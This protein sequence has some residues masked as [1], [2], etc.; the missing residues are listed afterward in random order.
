MV[1][2]IPLHEELAKIAPISV[3]SENIDGEINVSYLSEPTAEERSAVDQVVYQWPL[4]KSK[5]EADEEIDEAV[6]QVEEAGFDTG[7]GY[8]IDLSTKGS[9]DLTGSVVLAKETVSRDYDGMHF[10]LDNQGITQSVS[11]EE[12]IEISIEYGKARNALYILASQKTLRIR[13]AGT[14][15]E[16]R[17]IK[18]SS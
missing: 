10:I 13:Q 8:R 14:V 17:K 1:L 2:L 6:R 16:V 11:Y 7:K 15:E 5:L 18:F 3:V 9:S 12:L 4:E